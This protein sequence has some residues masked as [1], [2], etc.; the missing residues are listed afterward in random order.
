[1]CVPVCLS[2][3]VCVCVRACV[4]PC[5][6]VCMCVCVCMCVF[7]FVCPCVCVYCMCVPVCVSLC[8]CMCVCAVCVCVCVRVCGIRNPLFR[9]DENYPQNEL[10]IG[11][12]D[13]STPFSIPPFFSG[14]GLAW[15]VDGRHARGEGAQGSLGTV[16]ARVWGRGGVR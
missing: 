5:V 8:V 16:C 11:N 6:R 10:I 3:C 7:L 4:C 2:L 13:S 14:W 12:R 15:A 9:P 1:M